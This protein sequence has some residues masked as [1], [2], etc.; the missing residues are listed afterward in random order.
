ME[1]EMV[2]HSLR[3]GSLREDLQRTEKCN[4]A[5]P[6][7]QNTMEY[8]SA[9]GEATSHFLSEPNISLHN[10]ISNTFIFCSAC[11]PLSA[12]KKKK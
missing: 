5:P 2:E 3:P 10:M 9:K 12:H 4:K 11:C 7:T 8:N 6:K 1:P